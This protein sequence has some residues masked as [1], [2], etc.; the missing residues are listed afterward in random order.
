MIVNE[1]PQEEIQR[2][3]EEYGEEKFAKQIAKAIVRQREVEKIETTFQLKEIIEKVVKSS[4]NIHGATRSFQALRIAVNDEL[5]GLQKALPNALS[6]LSS[7]GR[8]VI[9]SFHSLEDRIVKN[10][11][12]DSEKEGIVK[13]LTKKPVMAQI[14]EVSQNPR[15][16]S[17]KLRAIIKI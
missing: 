6:V 16:R 8:L 14:G 2:I 11:F 17:A 5:G 4:G 3:L 9:I 10:F 15:A 13:I 7:G 12:K 1:Y